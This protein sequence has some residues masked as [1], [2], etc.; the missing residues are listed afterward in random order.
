MKPFRLA[1]IFVA[2]FFI[3]HY[4]DA[5][6]KWWRYGVDETIVIP[7]KQQPRIIDTLGQTFFISE[8]EYGMVIINKAKGAGSYY[9][10]E[11]YDR[12]NESF[13]K[14][15][16]LNGQIELISHYSDTL[17]DVPCIRFTFRRSAENLEGQGL[18]FVAGDYAYGLQFIHTPE[19]ATNASVEREYFFEN[20]E[21][22][23]NATIGRAQAKGFGYMI[24]MSLGILVMIM[25]PLALIAGVVLLIRYYRKRRR[26]V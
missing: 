22:S 15:V 25:V 11:D 16:T 4:S 10:K 23:V 21:F 13:L 9:T 20:I 17:K 7:V 6:N 8:T 24:G 18:G 2:L 1:L 12:F 26:A 14:G 5:Q 3:F 19:N